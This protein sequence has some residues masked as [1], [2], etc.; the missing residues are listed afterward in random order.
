[1]NK[2]KK[3]LKERLADGESILGTWCLLP[4]EAAANVI[5]RSG[6]DFI[7]VDMEHGPIDYSCAFRMTIAANAEGAGVIA[8]VS[9]N[10]ESEIL[11]VLDIGVDGVIIPH[12]ESAEERRKAVSFIKYPP[13]GIRGFSP[14]VRA[15]GYT[16]G[17]DYTNIQNKRTLTGIII[18]GTDGIAGID[19]IIDDPLVDLIY[20]GAYDIS[21]ALGIPGDVHNPKVIKV[22]TSCAKKIHSR[23][24]VS[25]ALFHSSQELEFFKSIGVQFLCYRVDADVL[26]SGFRSMVNEF[27]R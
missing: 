13:H 1:M 24:K 9:S 8:R 10:N 4:S 16:P 25:G 26:F 7:L 22:L 5:A 17:N 23:K 18:E 2:L 27:R 21:V 3:N 15:G 11:K 14:Y 6:V 12:I 19:S 20:L